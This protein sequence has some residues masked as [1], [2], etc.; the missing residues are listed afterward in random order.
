MNCPCG[1]IG[2]SPVGAGFKPAPTPQGKRANRGTIPREAA[3]I[4]GFSVNS[5]ATGVSAEMD[6]SGPVVASTAMPR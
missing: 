5:D 3:L 6:H 1:F 4:L 2:S